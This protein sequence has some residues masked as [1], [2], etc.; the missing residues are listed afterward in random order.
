MYV[1]I[2]QGFNFVLIRILNLTYNYLVTLLQ[3]L[4]YNIALENIKFQ[5]LNLRLI[6][7][8]EMLN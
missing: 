2:A 4:V 1:Y 8:S 3:N 6:S 5:R 7:I